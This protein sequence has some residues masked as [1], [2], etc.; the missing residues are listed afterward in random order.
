M[1][2]FVMKKFDKISLFRNVNKYFNWKRQMYNRF[3]IMNLIEYLKNNKIDNLIVKKIK[4][5]NKKNRKIRVL[6][7]M[8]FDLNFIIFVKNFE[9]IKIIWKKFV[10]KYK[11]KNFEHVNFI[12]DV[13]N[14]CKFFDFFFIDD[15]VEKLLEL[16]NQLKIYTFKKI[17]DFSKSYFIYRFHF[18]FDSKWIFYCEIYV[19]FHVTY[20]NDN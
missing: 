5:W 18:N 20:N 4:I 9:T 12:Y 17:H 11:I 10:K 6:I 3:E 8:R 16:N 1:K 14:F 2:F 15:Y 13:L 7:R 19:Q